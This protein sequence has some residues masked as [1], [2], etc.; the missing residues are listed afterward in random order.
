MKLQQQVHCDNTKRQ[1]SAQ[2]HFQRYL[3]L[4]LPQN[5]TCPAIGD[6]NAAVAMKHQLLSSPPL[7]EVQTELPTEVVGFFSNIDFFALF[8]VK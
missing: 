4:N 5:F 7:T 8:I 1:I 3:S 6:P 2:R